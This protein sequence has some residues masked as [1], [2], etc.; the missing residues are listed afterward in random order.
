MSRQQ[1][2]KEQRKY[3]DILALFERA[4]DEKE[5]SRVPVCYLVINGILMKKKCVHKMIQQKPSGLLTT[6]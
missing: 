4:S 3:S 2:S 1:L 6:R 5:I